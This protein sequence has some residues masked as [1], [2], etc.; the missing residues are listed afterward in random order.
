MRLGVNG[1]C[2]GVLCCVMQA[3]KERAALL[4][5]QNSRMNSE[6]SAA[7]AAHNKLTQQLAAA[8][9]QNGKLSQQLAGQEAAQSRFNQQISSAD[10]HNAK[11]MQQLSAAEGEVSALRSEVSL[12][13]TSRQQLDMNCEQMRQ[14]QQDQQRH[15]AQLQNEVS[16]A[17]QEIMV[18]AV[19]ASRGI[20]VEGHGWSLNQGPV[21]LALGAL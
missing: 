1:V 16:Q 10:A 18:R 20:A 19:W 12:L 11:L 21:G 13:Q 3:A 14:L 5:A 17:T 9:L 7:E 2:C 4:E 15:L 6:L 8:D